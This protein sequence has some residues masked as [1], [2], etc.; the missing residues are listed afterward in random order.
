V[1]NHPLSGSELQRLAVDGH[2][3]RVGLEGDEIVDALHL[4]VGVAV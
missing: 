1:R 2:G 3:D 4:A